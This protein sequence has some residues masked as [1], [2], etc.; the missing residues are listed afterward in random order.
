MLLSARRHILSVVVLAFWLVASGCNSQTANTSQPQQQPVSTVDLPAV[1][2][3]L[4]EIATSGNLSD[5]HWPN[6]TDYRLHFQHVYEASNFAPVWL[7]NG[8]PTPQ[9]LA[10]IQALQASKQKGLNP[11]DYD[12]FAGRIASMGSTALPL[13]TR[14][15]VSMRR[16]LLG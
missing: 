11:D 5:L 9:A 4:H 15:P 3:R 6:F 10:V 2:S 14:W 12:A 13:P 16:S 7:S 8:K 1:S